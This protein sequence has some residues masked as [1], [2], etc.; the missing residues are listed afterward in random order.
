MIIRRIRLR[1]QL[2][3]VLVLQFN[4]HMMIYVHVEN[5]THIL[6][7]TK[8]QLDKLAKALNDNVG[9]RIETSKAQL[10]H[11]KQLEGGFIGSLIADLASAALP[12]LASFVM[13]KIGKGIH[14]KR[15]V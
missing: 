5:Q 15:G 3:K 7:L 10:E 11:N 14:L 1:R 8:G 13:D 4:Y 9:V 12:S 2:M 6:A